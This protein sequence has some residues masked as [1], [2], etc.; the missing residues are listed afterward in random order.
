MKL[1]PFRDLIKMS[2]EKLD[3]AMAP[4][5]AHK[6]KTQAQLKQAEIDEQIVTLETEIQEMCCQ[7]DIAFDT[8]ISKLDRVAILERR[9]NQYGKI[10]KELFPA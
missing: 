9:Q 1:K 8:L 6:V 10:L 3:E 2:K 4:V 7:K 5:R